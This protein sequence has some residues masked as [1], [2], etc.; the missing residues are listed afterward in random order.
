MS[1]ILVNPFEGRGFKLA[2]VEDIRDI[3]IDETVK[4]AF[5]K[6]CSLSYGDS[7]ITLLRK[8][9]LDVL[10]QMQLNILLQKIT[11]ETEKSKVG[12]EVTG[13]YLSRLIQLS[14]SKG[15]DNFVLMFKEG[16]S[17]LGYNLKGKFGKPLNITLYGDA[18]DHCGAESKYLNMNISGN[19]TGY[20]GSHSDSCKYVLNGS[21]QNSCGSN[22]LLCDFEIS[23][24]V[25]SEL[26]FF[27]YLSKY[28]V[29]GKIGNNPGLE[30][31]V[32]TLKIQ[33]ERDFKRYCI[34]PVC[35]FWRIQLIDTNGE[36]L[37]EN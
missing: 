26:G 8:M 35:L 2:D 21:T 4:N 17:Y 23:G 37:K 30:S 10:N 13:M 7:K 3:S 6:Y 9:K 27:S 34:R 20:L 1:Q 11:R 36:V 28:T 22:A 14:Y 25:G 18:L 19:T 33:N 5:Q 12:D 24:N 29:Q 16:I 15:H 32:G 31:K